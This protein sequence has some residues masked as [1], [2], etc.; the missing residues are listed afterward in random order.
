[1]KKLLTLLALALVSTSVLAN[2]HEGKGE[3]KGA[4]KWFEKTDTN[5]DGAVSKEE[6]RA[7]QDEKFKKTDANNDGKI[8]KEEMQA[9]REK[10]KEERKKRKEERKDDKKESGEDRE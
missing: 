2:D 7:A 5:K 9:H 10:M 3:K 8:T 4:G 6:A 1:M